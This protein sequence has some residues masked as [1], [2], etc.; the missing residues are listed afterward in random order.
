[1]SHPITAVH[2]KSIRHFKCMP[3]KWYVKSLPLI[4]AF[5]HWQRPH[6]AINC[7]VA[8]QNSHIAQWIW[9]TCYAW[10]KWPQIDSLWAA[11]RRWSL[12]LIWPRLPK[13][14]WWVFVFVPIPL[15]FTGNFY[16]L[17][18]L[19]WCHRLCSISASSEIFV[20]WWCIWNCSSAWSQLIEHW[21]YRTNA[22]REPLGFRCS[23]Q[24]F[25]FVWF[26][27]ASRAAAMRSHFN[28]TRSTDATQCNCTDSSA[29]RTIL[30]SLSATRVQPIGCYF[31]HGTN[32]IGR[33]GWIDRTQSL[34]VSS[35]SDWKNPVLT[36]N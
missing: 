22:W 15:D 2:C 10:F 23:R 24:L 17:L 31:G 36:S 21:T 5:W 13:P 27:G 12:I 20:C 11:I 4:R 32:S 9:P 30:A 34:H 1:M 8:F 16:F 7:G 33:Y 28:R 19:L 3:T 25:D 18:A 26:C 35:K 29:H 14:N 6:C